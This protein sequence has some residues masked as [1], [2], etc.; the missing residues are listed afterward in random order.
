M[1]YL[2]RE[3]FDLGAECQGDAESSMESARL[4]A[5]Q[6][7]A[8]F[9][10]TPSTDPRKCA[11]GI[12]LGRLYRESEQKELAWRTLFPLLEPCLSGEHWQDAVEVCEGLY[13]CEQPNALVALGHALWLSVTFPVDPTLTVCQLQYVIDET[14]E[15]SDGAAVAAAVAAYVVDLRGENAQNSDAVLAVG[16]MFNDVARRHSGVSSPQQFDDWVKRME[17]DRPERFLVRLRN[18]ID[19]LVQDEWWFDRASLQARIP[20]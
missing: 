4:R 20:E 3:Q 2:N 19:V 18:I 16:R 7:A 9:E 6:V 17:L 14:P 5:S 15:D 12:E 10:K 13:L 1:N 8:Q 11:L